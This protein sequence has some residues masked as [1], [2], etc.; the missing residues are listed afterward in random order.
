MIKTIL[1]YN[2]IETAIKF[3]IV[4]G[5]YSRFHGVIFNTM[6]NHDHAAECGLFLFNSDG[7]M[8]I[9]FSE[10]IKLI[11]GK[12]WDKVAMITWLP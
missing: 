1:F 4:E 5:D 12:D 6:T 3:A 10:D 11:E 7:I 2:D 8:N 9:E